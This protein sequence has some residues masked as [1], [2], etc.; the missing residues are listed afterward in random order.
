[1]GVQGVCHG[2]CLVFKSCPPYEQLY[3]FCV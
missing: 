2:G 1:V 3:P